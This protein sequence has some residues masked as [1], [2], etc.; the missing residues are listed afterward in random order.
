[1]APG[2]A[3]VQTS[4]PETSA[5]AP[6]ADVLPSDVV[7]LGFRLVLIGTVYFVPGMQLTANRELQR[8]LIISFVGCQISADFALC[9]EHS[10]P[11]WLRLCCQSSQLM[12][13]AECVE[14]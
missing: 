13:T 3:V 9:F 5:P 8:K 7:N 6:S 1:M 12:I 11:A 14:S 4:A 10:V 2:P